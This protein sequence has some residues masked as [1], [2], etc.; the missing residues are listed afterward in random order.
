M[1]KLLVSTL[2]LA[3]DGTVEPDTFNKLVR[4]LELNLGE[5]DPDNTR[6]ITT[7][8]K[9]D[10]KF[11]LGS[12]V[13]DTTLEKLQIYNGTEWLDIDT[14]STSIHSGPPTNGL[15][16]QASLGILSVSTNGGITITL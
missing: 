12:I 10:N 4:I 15:E 16:A 13:F 11:N 3:Y 5:F 9:L 14:T 2:P 1:S 7:T 8:E 6:Q